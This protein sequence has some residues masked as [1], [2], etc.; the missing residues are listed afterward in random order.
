MTKQTFIGAY[1]RQRAN[2]RPAPTPAPQPM[3]E[4]PDA[5]SGITDEADSNA[6]S[7]ARAPQPS[8][9]DSISVADTTQIWLGELDGKAL[10]IDTPVEPATLPIEGENASPEQTLP[11]MPVELSAETSQERLPR[12]V[13]P[14]P[15]PKT[16]VDTPASIEEPLRNE[17]SVSPEALGRIDSPAPVQESAAPVVEPLAD[18]PVQEASPSRTASN[19]W[20]GAAWEVDAFDV[21]QS[22]STLFFDEAFFRSI[23]GQM[24][25]SVEAGLKTMM[26]TSLTSGAGRSTV[27]IGTAI[28]A[29]AAGIRVALVDM[30]L[31]NPRLLEHLR[32]DSEA[33]WVAALRHDDSLESIAIYS[34]EDSLTLVPLAMDEER[35][36]PVSAVETERLIQAL[37]GK[38]DLLIFDAPKVSAWATQQ[39]AATVDSCL[40][41]RDTRSTSHA[42]ITD[43]ADVLRGQGLR[44]LGVVDNFCS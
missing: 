9:H 27:A 2:R 34:I 16:F 28:A 38:F 24:Q 32:L 14:S 21:P 30:D 33:D 39:L 29:A 20:T 19:R 10:R 11:P 4:G 17:E 3:A 37:D 26:I 7:T 23:A 42:E 44:G 31:E 13:D 18:I 5:A 41:V 15:A 36:L 6:A 43:F 8:I 12:V 35:T 40:I 22:V 1:A 25:E